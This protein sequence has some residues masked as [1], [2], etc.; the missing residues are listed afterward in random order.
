MAKTHPTYKI[1]LVTYNEVTVFGDGMSDKTDTLTENK[2][3]FL[4]CHVDG[5]RYG[6]DEMNRSNQHTERIALPSKELPPFGTAKCQFTDNRLAKRCRTNPVINEFLTLLSVCHSIIPE[7]PSGRDGEVV[8]NASSPDEKA[9][10]L[11]SK[12]MHYYFYDGHVQILDFDGYD[13]Q[14]DGHRF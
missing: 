5:V 14:I 3:A 2:M 11:L 4:K 13:A 10:V 1:G 8:Y 6:P 12:N 7:Y 9:L